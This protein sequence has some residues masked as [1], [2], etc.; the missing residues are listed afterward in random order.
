MNTQ[1][2]AIHFKADRKLKDYINTKLEKLETFSDEIIDT[3]VFLKVENT[4]AKANKIIEIK[5]NAKHNTF[6]QKE[7]SISFEAATDIAVEA[8]K[9]QVKRSKGKAVVY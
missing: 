5:V 4:S 9:V 1:I 6:M 3:Q 2:Q 7:T 8:L